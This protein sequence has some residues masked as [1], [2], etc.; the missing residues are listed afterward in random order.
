MKMDAPKEI[1]GEFRPISTNVDGIQITEH[2]PKL[3]K[4]M[5]RCTLIRSMSDCDTR[6][7]AF[8][9]SH[10]AALQGAASRWLALFWLRG[11]EGAGGARSGGAVVCRAGAEDGPYGMG[12]AAESRASSASPMRPSSR[13]KAAPWRI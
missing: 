10:R 4:M 3:A 7:D 9:V 12:R 6:H 11:L 8:S 2:L 5:D 13:T 1:R